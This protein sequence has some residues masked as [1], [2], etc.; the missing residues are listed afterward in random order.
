[1]KEFGFEKIRLYENDCREIMAS[2][3]C[4]EYDLAVC[5]PDYGLGRKLR[6]GTW[7]TRWGDDGS[8]LGGVPDAGYFDELRRVSVNQI[9]WGGNYF[10]NH[11]YPTRCYLI[12]N[13]K[14]RPPKMADCE[15]AWTSF[16]KNAKVFTSARNPGG[17]S[18]KGRIHVCQ[19]PVQLYLW[20]YENY[21]LPGQKVLDTHLGSGSSMI[22]AWEIN[23]I[24]RSQGKQEIE[25]VGIEINPQY[26]DSAVERFMRHVE[27][28]S[29][30]LEV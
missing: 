5:D 30:R 15:M 10:I 7:A 1:M 19:K 18:G 13:K 6:G 17:I 12:W 8:G 9:I 24:L 20:I 16:D 14:D 22:A 27:K 29:D 26:F 25:F 3:G 2:M 28:H 4:R 11:L 23:K 21:V